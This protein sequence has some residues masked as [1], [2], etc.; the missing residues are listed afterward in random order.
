MNP[1]KIQLLLDGAQQVSQAL[2]KI[3]NDAQQ[4]F[5]KVS[6]A[7]KGST[8]GVGAAEQAIAVLTKR[9]DLSNRA[10]ERLRQSG[11]LTAEQLA[12]MDALRTERNTPRV[13][14]R[15]ALQV[16]DARQT[17][18]VKP[19]ADVGAEIAKTRQAYATLAASGKLTHAELLQASLRQQ[20]AVADL[21]A[22]TN[23]WAQSLATVKGQ[24]AALAGVAVGFTLAAREAIAFESAMADVRK[25]VDATPEGFAQIARSIRD[26]S[27]ELP[28][29]AVGLAQMAEA[30]GQL[31]I[32][33]D[34]IPEFVRLAS[35]MSVAFKMSAEESGTAVGK[36]GNIFGLT[37]P[38]VRALADSVNALGDSSAATERDIVNVLQ[39]TGGLGRQ[40]GLTAQQTSGL[41]TAFLSLGDPPEIAA[42]AI[43]NLLGKLQAAPAQSADFQRTLK[44]LG[45]DARQLASDIEGDAAGALLGFLATL[46]KLD[47]KSRSQA[48]SMM[49]GTGGDTASIAKLVGELGKLDTALQTATGTAAQGGLG[50]A[51]KLQADTA[52]SQMQLMRNGLAD[53]G[54]A[55]GAAMLPV[56]KAVSQAVAALARMASA[57]ADVAPWVLQSAAVMGVAV[58]ASGALRMAMTAASL[59]AARMG[60]SLGAAAAGT[61]AAG[62][63]SAAAAPGVAL[64]GGAFRVLLGPIGLVVLALEGL[65]LMW[66]KWQAAKDAD[67]AKTE[68]DLQGDLARL[69]EERAALRERMRTGGYHL[70]SQARLNS[71]K[72]QEADL[73]E[74]IAAKRRE[75]EAALRE[76]A[77]PRGGA[78]EGYETEDKV[79]LTA[80]L[81]AATAEAQAAEKARLA[82]ARESAAARAALDADT[83][84]RSLAELQRALERE[85]VTLDTYYAEKRSR[86]EADVDAQIGL[87]QRE[88]TALAASKPESA[89][90][91]ETQKGALAKLAAEIEQLQR[92]RNRIGLDL[93]REKADA[94]LKLTEE[95][96]RAR[97]AAERR[98]AD[99]ALDL[100]RQAHAQGLSGAAELAAAEALVAERRVQ[101]EIDAAQRILNARRTAN[102]PAASIREAAEQVDAA[103][104]RQRDTRTQR[105]ADMGQRVRALREQAADIRLQLDADPAR[106]AVAEAGRDVAR[107]RDQAE[108]DRAVLQVQL[109]VEADPEAR[110]RIRALLT[111]LDAA[112]AD[113]VVARN[114][115]LT[116]DLKPGWQKMVEGWH[117]AQRLMRDAADETMDRLVRG[118][119][120]AF[121]ELAKTGR[122]NVKSLFKDLQG[123]AGR[124]V[125][126][127]MLGSEQGQRATG[128]LSGL[129]KPAAKDGDPG[130]MGPLQPQAGAAAEAADPVRDLARAAV[131]AAEALR[132]IAAGGAPGARGAVGAGQLAGLSAQSG[133]SVKGYSGTEGDA[134]FMGPL[135]EQAASVERSA[136]AAD[137]MAASADQAASANALQAAAAAA[138]ATGFGRLAGMLN[139]ATMATALFEAA[140]KAAAAIKLAT[141]GSA[142]GHV[143]T[144]A[145]RFAAGGAF[146]N[147]IVSSPTLFRFAHGG[148][149]HL[150]EMGEAGPE[151]IM[152]LEGGNKVTALDAAGRRVGA[153]SLARGRGGRLSVV[154]D[155]AAQ[156]VS[157]YALGG[158][159]GAAALLAAPPLRFAAGGVL[160]GT[161]GLGAAVPAVA[162]QGAAGFARRDGVDGSLTLNMVA[163][164]P[165]GASRNDV[166]QAMRQARAE[167]VAEIEDRMRRNRAQ[168]RS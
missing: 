59:A 105:L 24:F 41:A 153:L 94:L 71:L 98:G 110:Q 141:A 49:F 68:S 126:R 155:N 118:G 20:Q 164:V 45:I 55:M 167:A 65:I 69:R 162:M 106:R 74:R 29:T 64:L 37:L 51:L 136:A 5:G 34:R 50:R 111:T 124:L 125:W 62:A 132:G 165:A 57:V 56:I 151:A 63:A 131:G 96:S 135:D 2:G 19:F 7:G 23:G 144:G 60:L 36:L 102:A 86:A 87:K 133:L 154:L 115:R 93:A 138:N 54:I 146:T 17:L 76:S 100:A 28:V 30:G 161:G 13:Q 108:A 160:G 6:Q 33:G 114:D 122:L 130:F 85:T 148:R 84:A 116:E 99:A 4:A 156:A 145:Q 32:A 75:R 142:V 109:Q 137:R 72:R 42:T 26:L 38:Q 21:R 18:G 150:G 66:N 91:Q 168:Y 48:L 46:E 35:E 112:T 95:S 107:L 147:K 163:N 101:L 39:R 88:R 166:L 104:D 82:A 3:V 40:F 121:A 92:N 139:L 143:F 70:E 80:Q 73:E 90:E 25:V 22:Q 113:A 149:M 79:D 81:R 128:W 58:A 52:A 53:I 27:A 129:L 158:G 134:N 123:Q 127:Q 77:G 120:D 9:I 31:G 78:G 83:N 67:A 119:E 10:F 14:E 15:S 103:R 47:S 43:N 117:D 152:P 89:A 61:A 8:V 11:R 97:L 140:T 12:K 44:A 157:R 1:I 159:F 16:A